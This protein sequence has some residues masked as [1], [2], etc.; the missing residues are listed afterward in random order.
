MT[1]K[2]MGT[3]E[4]EKEKEKELEFKLLFA[5]FPTASRTRECSFGHPSAN[6]FNAGRFS[7]QFAQVVQFCTANFTAAHDFQFRNPWCMDRK[8]SFHTNAVGNFADG[9]CLA[10]ACPAAADDDSFEQL[11]PFTV[12]FHNFYMNPDSVPRAKGRQVRT[13]LFFRNFF[14]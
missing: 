11:D 7:A 5:G 4:Y 9:K 12:A 14:Y 13:K 3:D 10:D 8:R 1:L 6:F 2:P